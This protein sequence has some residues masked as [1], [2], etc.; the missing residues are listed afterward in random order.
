MYIYVTCVWSHIDKLNNH[1]HIRMRIIKMF[2]NFT[3][4]F[5][6]DASSLYL[7][8]DS[9]KLTSFFTVRILENTIIKVNLIE[10]KSFELF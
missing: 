4:G 3:S 9:P 7:C 2:V 1:V 5:V 10:V 8:S 6:K